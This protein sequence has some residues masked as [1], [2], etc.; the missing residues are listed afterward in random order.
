MGG[1]A[2]HMMHPYEYTD[3]TG[4]D[5]INLIESLFSG[6]IENIK[7]KLDGFNLMATMNNNG[8]VVFIRNGSNLNSK[9]GGFTLDEINKIWEGK[10]QQIKVFTNAAKIIE[11]IFSRLGKEFF[12]PDPFHRKV[13]NCESIIVGQTNIMPYSSN[14]VAFHGY[15]LF[16]LI[17]NTW[18]EIDD[19]EG[20]V[21]DIY[22]VSQDI[23]EAKPR[24]NLTIH[25]PEIA[26]KLS[27]KF[28][29]KIKQLWDKE[30]LDINTTIND[31][32]WNRFKKF[33]PKWCNED[34]NIFNRICNDDK[35]VNLKELKKLYPEHID[36][37]NKLDKDIKKKIISKIMEPLDNLFLLI[38]NEIIDLLD[39]FVN[40]DNKEDIIKIL[41]YN[42]SDMIMLVDI[43]GT[44]EIDNQLKKSLKRLKALNNKYNAAEGIV[45]V[46]KNRRMKFTGSFAPINQ[47]LGLRF[48]MNKT[49]C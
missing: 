35:S 36:D 38:G 24:P 6:K 20:N 26:L 15:K 14:R 47:I 31:W 13:I 32:K 29:K 25:S 10:E 23:I 28:V 46:Y 30:D 11:Q 33:A 21:D 5:L 9:N 17:D 41:Q 40:S 44:K 4:N 22:N 7:E 49:N 48:D 37:L 45:I 1:F 2:K 16:E 8:Q 39:G 43:N 18:K 42:I 27:S 12:N 34:Y 19:I 3:F